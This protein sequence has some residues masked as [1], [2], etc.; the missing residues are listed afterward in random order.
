M[1]DSDEC[2]CG[3]DG[4]FYACIDGAIYGPCE[5]ETCGGVCEYEGDCKCSCHVSAGTYAQP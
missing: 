1:P 2:L 3:L 4:E 5:Y